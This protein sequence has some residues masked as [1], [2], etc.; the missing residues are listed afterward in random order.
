MKQLLLE[1]GD[2]LRVQN[3]SLPGGSF[4]K[5]Q[6][7]SV[8]FLD[9]TDPKAVYLSLSDC[10]HNVPTGWSLLTESLSHQIGIRIEQV[11]DHHKRR[12]CRIELQQQSL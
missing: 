11:L 7:Q 9:I 1:P 3:I 5:I 4:I 2:I 6:P 12:Y 8:D 10:A